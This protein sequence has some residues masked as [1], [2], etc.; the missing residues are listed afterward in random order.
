MLD[1]KGNLEKFDDNQHIVF[2]STLKI[3]DEIGNATRSL[4]TLYKYTDHIL[5]V[6]GDYASMDEFI[7]SFLKIEF[8]L[9]LYVGLLIA[10]LPF[11][12]DISNY[13]LIY[14]EAL[15]LSEEAN[16]TEKEI[17]TLLGGLNK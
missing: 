16:F 15:R 10:M 17:S 11:K 14:N 4:D 1:C 12:K 7:I 3:M 5:Y 13:E 2:L 9:Q 6:N 8:S